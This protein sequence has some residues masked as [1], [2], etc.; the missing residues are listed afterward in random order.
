MPVY[1]VQHG[2]SLPKEKD[3]DQ[4]LSDQGVQDTRRIAEV[5]VHY[6]ISVNQI[7][8]S[9]KKRARQTAAIFHAMLQPAAGMQEVPGIQPMDDVVRFAE[10]I[11]EEENIM[12][13][14]HLPFLARLVSYLL[15]GKT[16]P[17]VFQ[18]QNSGIVCLDKSGDDGTWI[19]K[20]TLM[21]NIG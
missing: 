15:L 7:L 19:I 11:R 6:Q 1:L 9:T 12:V 18:F 2:K 14:S 8:H 20:W 13:V 4:G 21:P 3:P 16:T 17:A 5:A 10:S